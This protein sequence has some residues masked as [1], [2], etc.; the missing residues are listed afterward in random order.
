MW[1]CRSLEILDL[2][3]KYDP[4]SVF[5]IFIKIKALLMQGES[6]KALNLLKPLMACEDVSPDFLRVRSCVVQRSH[7]S[8]HNCLTWLQAEE[9]DI[10]RRE[11]TLRWRKASKQVLPSAW[12]VSDAVQESAKALLVTSCSAGLLCATSKRDLPPFWVT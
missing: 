3:A 2:A 12:M 6:G 8:T 5:T 4:S 7:L 9:R 11:G 1:C 10:K